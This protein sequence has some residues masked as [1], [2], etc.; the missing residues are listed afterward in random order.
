MICQYLNSHLIRQVLSISI[1][2][3]F[4]Y[5]GYIYIPDFLCFQLAHERM[6][7]AQLEAASRQRMA[8]YRNLAQDAQGTSSNSQNGSASSA[9]ASML[10]SSA[11]AQKKD[12]TKK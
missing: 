5:S 4:I 3:V 7:M 6:K 12:E 10:K 9:L 1:V 11:T 8:Q 2:V